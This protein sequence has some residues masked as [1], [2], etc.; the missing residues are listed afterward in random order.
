[1]NKTFRHIALCVRLH[2]VSAWRL[3]ILCKKKKTKNKNKSKEQSPQP[4]DL[5][6]FNT[7]PLQDQR[8]W[9][10]ARWTRLLPERTAALVASMERRG[11]SAQRRSLLKAR[12]DV[13]LAPANTV[14]H[15][16]RLHLGFLAAL[17]TFSVLWMLHLYDKEKKS[18]GAG[19][20]NKSTDTT[21]L[22]G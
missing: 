10:R 18:F 6:C 16:A 7:F 17:W 9:R 8:N 15:L 13:L 20:V 11:G 14:L 2:R 1:M 19:G 22:G 4:Q 21:Y 12:K 5:T 3:A